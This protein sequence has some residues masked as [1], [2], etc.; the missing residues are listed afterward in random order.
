VLIDQPHEVID[1]GR[2]LTGVCHDTARQLVAEGPWGASDQ[3]R[4]R[5]RAAGCAEQ[6]DFNHD[7][8]FERLA[9]AW[10]AAIVSLVVMG[11]L[12]FAVVTMLIASLFFIL[13]FAWLY[14]ALLTFQLPGTGRELAWGWLVGLLKDLATVA[15]MSFVISYL[16]LAVSAF[17]TVPDLGLAQRFAVL[18]VVAL[19]MFVYRRRI[20]TGVANLVDR[21]RAEAASMR[22][23]SI[24]R[25]PRHGYTGG[26]TGG[27]AGMSGYGIGQRAR[28]AVME[29]PGSAAYEA[30][31]TGRK[32]RMRPPRRPSRSRT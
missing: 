9:S 20:L 17:L 3:P 6:A 4:D 2:P 14:V 21:V 30:A 26:G 1:W 5:M 19:A 10:M 18:I 24:G 32:L 25:S 28:E 27:P 12:L 8:T 13:R 7:P 22:P 31:H 11:L 29:M 16:M 23:G 15:G